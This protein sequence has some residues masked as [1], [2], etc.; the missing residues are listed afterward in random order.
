MRLSAALVI[1]TACIG[2]GAAP[3]LAQG[4]SAATAHAFAI[5]AQPLVDAM[6]EF[7]RATGIQIAY[8][9]S[10]GS[11]V[12]SPGVSGSFVPAEALSRLLTGTGLTFRY[13]GPNTVTLEPAPQAAGGAIQLGPVRVEGQGAGR[14]AS[15]TSDPAATEGT[16]RYTGSQTSTAS[17][18]PLTV[19]ETPQ[20]VTIVTRQRIDDFQMQT[21]QSV[22][23]NIV[24]ITE[25]RWDSDRGGFSARGFTI[26]NM[27]VD[28]IASPFTGAAQ[29]AINS[30]YL[31]TYLYDR[32]DVVRGATGLLSATG[33]PSATINLVRKKPGKEF[34]ASGF[35]AAG[36]RDLYRG[37]V[38]LSVP[39]TANGAVRARLIGLY[40]TADSFRV[41]AS[42]ERLL[43][44]ALLEFDLS[45]TTLLRVSNVYQDTESR[46]SSYGSLPR[47]Y[48]DGG[49][50]DLPRSTNLST[51]WSRVDKKENRT[52]ATLEQQVG[53]N[54][55]FVAAIGRT[56]LISN[57]KVYSWG[58]GAPDR[59]GNGRA[60]YPWDTDGKR[61]QWTPT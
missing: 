10:I 46:G 38:D 2:L 49:R 48:D 33:D 29:S 9:A 34:A 55:T 4:A 60:M 26:S 13:T 59:A 61:T 1:G 44:S 28:G 5:G 18:L 23:T 39:I 52:D 7:S 20:A 6:R 16:G 54:W 41:R 27:Q 30:P 42:D 40:H 36:S 32:I 24:G 17:R 45:P 3:A 58:Y 8:T 22:L 57:P 19:K 47:Y 31:D 14:H 35:L 21:V 51:T 43:L 12:T 25:E 15:L 37:G 11:G 50:L 56:R 53:E